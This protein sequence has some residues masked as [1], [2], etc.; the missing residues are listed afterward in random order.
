MRGISIPLESD[1]NINTFYNEL[2]RNSSNIPG[3]EVN[4]VNDDSIVFSFDLLNRPSRNG[5]S[6][7]GATGSGPR[8]I[9]D[10]D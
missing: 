2:L 8:N 1:I 4:A 7:A 3:F 6:G 10:V 9:D 5:A